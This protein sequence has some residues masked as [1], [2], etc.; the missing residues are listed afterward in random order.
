MSKKIE[1]A[2][3]NVEN[4]ENKTLEGT[5]ADNMEEAQKAKAVEPAQTEKPHK[6]KKFFAGLWEGTKKAGKA[7]NEFAHEHPWVTGGILLGAG[8]G[9]EY[10]R[11]KLTGSD[12]EEPEASKPDVYYIMPAKSD[13]DQEE[14]KP[15]VDDDV[16]EEELDEDQDEEDDSE[17]DEEESDEDDIEVE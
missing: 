11:E 4:E 16:E 2:N 8:V 10:L 13:D 12:D 6:V 7:V 3:V 5:V 9:I 1:N 17:E 14:E 15:V